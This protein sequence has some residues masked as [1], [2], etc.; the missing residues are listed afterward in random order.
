MKKTGKLMLTVVLFVLMLL[1]AA[2]CASSGSGQQGSAE[3]PKLI[4]GVTE[5]EPMNYRD[6]GGNWTG[7]DTEFALLVGEKLGMDVSFQEIDWGRKFA[8]LESGAINCIWNGFTANVVDSTTGRPRIEE[9]DMSYSYMLNQQCV[10]VRTDRAGEFRSVADMAGKT[11]AAEKG[12][13]GETFAEEAVGTTGTIIDSAAQINTFTEVK[14][15]AVDCAVIDILL[16]QKIAGSGDY[17]DLVIADIVL[18]HELYA[19]GFKKGSDL[20]A[21]VNEAM[22]ALYDEGK[23]MQLAEKYGLENTLSLDT[24]FGK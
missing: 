20:T 5:Y 21:K 17:A 1:L 8:E 24:T 7:F 2:S 18:D 13:A 9:V 6:A 22:K 16:A 15:G 3:K 23:L 12:S 10:V 19:I 4:C 11:A 14:A